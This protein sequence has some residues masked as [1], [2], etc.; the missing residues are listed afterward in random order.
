MDRKW[1]IGVVFV[2]AFVM[3]IAPVSGSSV[4]L[5]GGSHAEPAFTDN[6]LTLTGAGE[7]A[8]LGNGDVLVT[9]AAWANPTATCGNPGSNT[10]EAPGQNPAP[11]EVTGS[12]AI[13]DSEIKN[14]NTPFTVTTN[15]PATPIP[16]APDCPNPQWTEEIR[17][18]AFTSLTITVEQPA[19]TT[20]LTV[21]CTFS[22]P[23]TDGS[24]AK[25]DVS[26]SS[27]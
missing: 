25:A 10:W 4:H 19:G 12:V 15:S 23:T 13:P 5:K 27:S 7:L 11:V 17:D 8:G 14:G 21:S 20:V 1:L 18:M 22:S 16:G 2:A 6:G 3:L 24:V 9:L 26:C